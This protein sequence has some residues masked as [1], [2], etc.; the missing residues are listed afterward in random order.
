MNYQKLFQSKSIRAAVRWENPEEQLVPRDGADLSFNLRP[1]DWVYK[2]GP[3]IKVLE[4]FES[5]GLVK[6]ISGGECEAL[7]N[8]P[9][10]VRH[11]CAFYGSGRNV[12]VIS[13]ISDEHHSLT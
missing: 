10:P 1:T 12:A 11:T 2:P 3:K 8:G 13:I 9:L 6:P 7:G 5:C 4:H